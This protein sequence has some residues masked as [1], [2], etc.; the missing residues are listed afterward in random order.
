MTA[1]AIW[2]L[3]NEPRKGR[4]AATTSMATPTFIGKPT[5]KMFTWGTTLAI[6]PKATSVI[7]SAR[8]TGADTSTAETKIVAKACSTP[9]VRVAICGALVSGTRSKVRCRPRRVQASPPMAMNI[10]RPTRL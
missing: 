6:I 8:M 2:L 9:V 1:L 7:I 10:A 4:E 3:M 5:P